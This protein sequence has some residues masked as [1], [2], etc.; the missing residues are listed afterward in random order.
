VNAGA[1]LVDHFDRRP[2]GDAAGDDKE[3]LVGA[4]GLRVE[5]NNAWSAMAAR[6]AAFARQ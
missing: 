6:I 2:S 5:E 3:A 4:L 1:K